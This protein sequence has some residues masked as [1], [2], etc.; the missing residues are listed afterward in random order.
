MQSANIRV[1]NL[2]CRSG[3]QSHRL[4]VTRLRYVQ[5]SSS[6]WSDPYNHRRRHKL[7]SLAVR[8]SRSQPNSLITTYP[9]EGSS[10]HARCPASDQQEPTTISKPCQRSTFGMEHQLTGNQSTEPTSNQQSTED[11]LRKVRNWDTM[12]KRSHTP[13]LQLT[14][15]EQD[16]QGTTSTRYGP[17]TR[18]CKDLLPGKVVTYLL[19]I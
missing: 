12:S 14:E 6:E 4:S 11:T 16:T 8:T 9:D 2:Y 17:G 5:P 19:L 18:I 7:L 1:L 3:A 15:G 13:T 10:D